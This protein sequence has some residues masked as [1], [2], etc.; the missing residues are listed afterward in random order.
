MTSKCWHLKWNIVDYPDSAGGQ[1]C[2]FSELSA[3][4]NIERVSKSLIEQTLMFLRF[5]RK[6]KDEQISAEQTPGKQPQHG[7]FREIKFLANP[8]TK[9]TSSRR[10]TLIN[11]MRT[12]VRVFLK[13]LASDST[14]CLR[15]TE[16]AVMAWKAKQVLKASVQRPREHV[17]GVSKQ[18]CTFAGFLSAELIATCAAAAPIILIT[19]KKI[20]RLRVQFSQV[21][22]KSTWRVSANV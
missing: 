12:E 7:K 11:W 18:L 5:I 17:A 10:H 4:T 16:P 21:L 9:K 8:L 14:G 3:R 20:C 13:G 6:D 19:G 22:Q 1:E 2:N 15:D